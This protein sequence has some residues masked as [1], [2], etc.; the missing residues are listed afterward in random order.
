MNPELLMKSEVERS[1]V[2]ESDLW[3]GLKSQ[4]VDRGRRA[5]MIVLFSIAKVPIL[6]SCGGGNSSSGGGSRPPGEC[7]NGNPP[8]MCSNK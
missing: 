4:A 3:T 8:G 5:V 6:S 7:N 1:L 2:K